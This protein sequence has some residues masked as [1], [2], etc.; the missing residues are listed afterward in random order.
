MNENSLAL[1]LLKQV[2]SDSR[3]WFIAFITTLIL[4]FASNMAWLYA[5][6]LPADEV[7][8]SS[9]D[10]T[11]DIDSGTDGNAIYNDS[12]EVNVDGKN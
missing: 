6:N 3:K 8:D 9:V 7:A 11:Y 4:F 5:W 2:K 10:Y 12:G 1:E